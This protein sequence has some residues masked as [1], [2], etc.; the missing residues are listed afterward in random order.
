[1]R[2]FVK[3]A[4]LAIV[5]VFS[6]TLSLAAQS[7]AGVIVNNYAARDFVAGTVSKGDLDAI[8][9]AGVRSPSANNRQP[10]HFTVVQTLSVAQQ[11][12]PGTLDGN[13]LIV[14]SATGPAD[15]AKY[16]DCAL[17]TENIYL[18]AQA[19]GL[20]SRIYTGPISAVNSRHKA[21]LGIPA[22]QTAV[23]I[24]RVGK[25]RGGLDATSGAS[26]RKSADA[27]VTYR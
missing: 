14:I 15:N 9:A 13:V 21:L 8:V 3:T 26:S 19:L 24:V 10:W 27:V 23:A 7:G 16:I 17:A 11:I 6:A 4:I 1:M 12:I 5:L 20:G 2:T 25:V 18:Q 22:D